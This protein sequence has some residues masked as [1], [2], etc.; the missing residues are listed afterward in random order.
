M[1]VLF[2]EFTDIAMMRKCLLGIERRAEAAA[3]AA[4]CDHAAPVTAS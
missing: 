2:V 4:E 1:V 3:T